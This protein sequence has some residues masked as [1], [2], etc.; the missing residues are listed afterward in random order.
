VSRAQAF[1]LGSRARP[2]CHSQKRRARGQAQ[3][4]RRRS[5][6]GVKFSGPVLRPVHAGQRSGSLSPGRPV[7]MTQ[8]ASGRSAGD[9]GNHA[10]RQRGDRERP[11]SS[12]CWPTACSNTRPRSAVCLSP[13]ESRCRANI[14]CD[15]CTL[16]VI[17]F[18]SNHALNNPVGCFYHHCAD[19]SIQ[20]GGA[21]Q[22]LRRPAARPSQGGTAAASG[23]ASAMTGQGGTATGVGGGG[24]A[25]S[26]GGAVMTAGGAS[27][28]AGGADTANGMSNA[29]C[30]CTLRRRSSGLAGLGTAFALAALLRRRRR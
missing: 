11:R 9:R 14:S 5:L 3:T 15:H 6:G 20:P 12:R 4:N 25:T 7:A 26:Q 27:A 23:G 10:L 29:G 22:A 18:I 13:F 16:Q 28:T 2:K 30:R 19:I 21:E 17:E 1:S 8:P 24:G